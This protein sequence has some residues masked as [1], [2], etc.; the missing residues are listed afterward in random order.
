TDD[1]PAMKAGIKAGDVITEYD[2]HKVAGA[3]DLPRLVADTPAGREV[4]VTLLRDGKTVR[5]QAK[6]ATL[7]DPDQKV[8]SEEGATGKRGAM[9]EPVPPAIAKE[10]G[11]KEAAGVVVRRVEDGSPADNAGIK[12]GDV[13]LEVDRQPVKDVKGLKGLIDKH[14]KGTPM[15]VLLHPEDATL[16]VG[17]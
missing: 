14:A 8:A 9:V 3:E 2:G 7:D 1:S 12:P 11:L 6:V 10:L 5:L 4:P 17:V 13:I 16:D 15:V